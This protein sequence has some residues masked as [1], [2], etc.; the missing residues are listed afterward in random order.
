MKVDG[1]KRLDY[2]IEPL[3]YNGWGMIHYINAMAG[4]RGT[5]QGVVRH[6]RGMILTVLLGAYAACRR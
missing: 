2:T 3:H 5:I 4:V 6:G 1:E